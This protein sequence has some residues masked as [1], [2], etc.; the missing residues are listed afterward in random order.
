MS[1]CTEELIEHVL[2]ARS[3][4]DALSIQGANSKAFSGRQ[5]QGTVLDTSAHRGIIDYNPVELVLTARAATPL[6]EIQAAL[7]EHG[8]ILSFE[9]PNFAGQSTLGGTLA[10]NLSGPA[11]PWG[12]SVRDHVLGL[13]LIN[14]RGELLRF[15][16]RVMKNVAGYDVSRLQ[17]GAMGSLGLITEISLKVLPG[18]AATVTLVFD[19]Q[20]DQ[21]IGQLNRFAAESKP[22][23]AA[24]WH[25]GRL[26]I[27]LSGAQSAVQATAE[28]WSTKLGGGQLLE[29]ADQFWAD[30]RD[31]R[32]AFFDG[33][34]PLWRF[35]INSTAPQLPLAG[36]TLV[37][38]AGALRWVRGEGDMHKMQQLAKDAGGEVSLFRGG[39]RSAEVLQAPATPVMAIQK[40]LKKTFDPDRVFNPG[41]SYSW[42]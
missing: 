8:Q 19:C 3:S 38:W 33:E 23:S 22:I 18:F 21:A 20:A 10:C 1:D 41:R 31:Q 27:R 13:S 5:A 7:S 28:Q 2:S 16:G 25:D 12:G 35:S 34:A 39:D 14:G 26:T 15:G 37:D 17:A 9:P 6:H 11:R 24:V 42:L 40:R 4:G 30:L 36:T 32:G 29:G